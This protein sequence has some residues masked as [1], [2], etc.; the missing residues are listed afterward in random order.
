M[1][2]RIK[3]WN[4]YNQALINRGSL[5][6]WISADLLEQWGVSEQ[7]GKR[8][9]PR[10]F[11][12]EC[13]LLMLTLRVVFSLP[14]RALQGFVT[15]LFDMR[16]FSLPVPSYTQICRRSKALDKK[17][18]RLTRRRPKR[19]VLDSTGLKVYGDGEWKA[20]KHGSK[21][22]RRWVKLHLSLCPDTHTIIDMELKRAPKQIVIKGWI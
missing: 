5:D 6:V 13:I 16:G 19:I 9:R 10:V 3:N 15:S 11:S 8:G 4:Q 7:S 14:L 2:C 12:D 1:S 22:Q 20:K 21:K 17:L 18:K